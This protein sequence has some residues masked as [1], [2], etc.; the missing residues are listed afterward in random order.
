M[1]GETFLTVGKTR[2]E[3]VVFSVGDRWLGVRSAGRQEWARVSTLAELA[4]FLEKVKADVS[5]EVLVQRSGAETTL[6]WT[7]YPADKQL[8]PLQPGKLVRAYD[9]FGFLFEA[10]PLIPSSECSLGRVRKNGSIEQQL[11]EGSYVFLLRLD[12]HA[13]TRLPVLIEPGKPSEHDLRLVAL[14]AAPP[15]FV[16]V[17]GGPFAHGGDSGAHEGLEPGTEDVAGFF[18]AQHEV[19]FGEYLGFLND[20][21]TLRRL[22]DAAV[23][24]ARQEKI[25]DPDYEPP[26]AGTASPAEDWRPEEAAA[27]LNRLDDENRYVA[28][29]PYYRRT[30]LVVKD[31]KTGRYSLE[32]GVHP[33][34]PLTGVSPLASIEY[35]QWLSRQHQARW[36]FRLPTEC[37]W[38]KAA[39]GVDGR[40]YVW[41]NYP[42]YAS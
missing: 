13:D 23:E 31:D 41:G 40:T 8:G 7:P 35:A 3:D 19:T 12:G 11:P 39:R 36:K 22:E 20:P 10:Y 34:W 32:D 25:D 33:N 21:M 17:C 2:Q 16:Y 15:N 14:E 29:V 9:Q 27:I 5:V 18:M 37:E 4:R 30:S 28:L 6:N 38:E 42:I 26:P 24:R 1:V